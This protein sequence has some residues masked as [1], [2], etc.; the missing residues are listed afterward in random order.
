MRVKTWTW[1]H[2]EGMGL[3]VG[4][5]A[6]WLADGTP[7]WVRGEGSSASILQRWAPAI[8]LWLDTF[9]VRKEE[10]ECVVVGFFAGYP[11]KQLVDLDTGRPA[12]PGVLE[13]RYRVDFQNGRQVRMRSKGELSLVEREGN[14]KITGRLGLNEYVARVIDREASAEPLEAAK[15][16]AVAART[17]LLQNA[18]H[19]LGCYQ[20]NDSSRT[21]RVSPSPPSEAARGIAAWTDGLIVKGVPIHYHYDQPGPNTMAWTRAAALAREKRTFDQILADA[22]PLGDLGSMYGDMKRECQQMPEA[23]IWL[24]KESRRWQQMLAGEPGFEAPSGNLT[25]CRLQ[26]GDPYSNFSRKRLYVRGLHSINDRLALAHEYLHIGFRRH[27]RGA[28]EQ[29]IEEMA[30]RLIGE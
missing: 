10:T 9:P 4:G 8:S 5:F 28:D 11:L 17:Y 2:P 22:Y 23:E 27:P 20:I 15:A 18:V 19:L 7:I 12:P 29:F 21:Q 24:K 1:D 16:L 6:G 26:H 14:L 3:R 13:G 30:Q 25:V